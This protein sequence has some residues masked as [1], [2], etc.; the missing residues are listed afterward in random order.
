M[1]TKTK[2]NGLYVGNTAKSLLES[3]GEN[4][5][6]GTRVFESDGTMMGPV[7]NNKQKPANHVTL[8]IKKDCYK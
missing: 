2:F 1:Y 8:F 6:I 3:F 5:P 7:E 4:N